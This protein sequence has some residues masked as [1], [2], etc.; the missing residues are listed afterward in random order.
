MTVGK[1]AAFRRVRPASHLNSTVGLAW[2]RRH[3]WASLKIESE[4]MLSFILIRF[5]VRWVSSPLILTTLSRWKSWVHESWRASP[6]PLL[7]VTLRRTEPS[8]HLGWPRWQWHGWASTKSMRIGQLS[9]RLLHL[10]E[11]VPFLDW[12]AQW[13]CL[14]RCECCCTGQSVYSRTHCNILYHNFV[15]VLLWGNY[16]YSLTLDNIFLFL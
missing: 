14:W 12:A 3:R 15:Y 11:W 6:V 9:C 1:L 7:V 2:S 13:S 5:E 8:P 16:C 10:G 4:W